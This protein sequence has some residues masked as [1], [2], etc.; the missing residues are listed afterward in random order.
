MNDA[1]PSAYHNVQGPKDLY[2]L[3]ACLTQS[4]AKIYLIYNVIQQGNSAN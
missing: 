4:K 1:A 3:N 2:F